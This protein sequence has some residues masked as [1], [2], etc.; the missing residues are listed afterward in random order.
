MLKMVSDNSPKIPIIAIIVTF[1]LFCG[2][3]TDNQNIPIPN[4]TNNHTGD[5]LVGLWK[6]K[7]DALKNP[8][9]GDTS[10]ASAYSISFLVNGTYVQIMSGNQISVGTW[11]S[12]GENETEYKYERWL[13]LGQGHFGVTHMLLNKKDNLLLLDTSAAENY[14]FKL[15]KLY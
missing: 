13:P 9:P 2:C 4:N 14:S 1:T 10:W 8:G 7:L 3:S 6:I 12:T 15:N 5:P 11:I